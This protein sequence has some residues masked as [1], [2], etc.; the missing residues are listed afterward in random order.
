MTLLGNTS[1]PDEQ[2]LDPLTTPPA[3]AAEEGRARRALPAGTA[4][5][6][7]LRRVHFMAGLVVA[8]FLA[9]LAL[10]GL[11]YAFTPQLNDLLYGDELH[12]AQVGSAPRPV[13]DQVEAA[14]ARHPDGKVA[15]VVLP[16][17]PERTTEV[18]LAVPG[19]DTAGGEFAAENLTVYVDPY[20]AGVTGELITVNGRPPAQVWLRELHGNLG[21]G[22]PGR[23]YSEL[24]ASWLP[25]ILV[26]GLVLWLGG[27]RRARAARRA[28]GRARMRG[29]HG[30]IGLWAAVGLLV[31]S[32]TGLT[33]SQYAGGR[34]DQ[35]IGAL[36]AKSPS[37]RS[38]PITIPEGVEPVGFD[39]VVTAARA[40]GLQ[41]Q[42][43]LTPPA[44]AG[45]PYKVNETSTGL[46]VQKDS[47]AVDPY[48][49]AVTG[50]LG[51]DDYPF[52]AKLTT[53]GIQAHS[54]T[55]FGMANQLVMALLALAALV[56]T[57]LG[58]LMWWRRR[59]RSGGPAPVPPPVWRHMSQP[60][61]FGLVAAAAVLGWAMP[62]FGVSLVAFVLVDAAIGALA[63]RRA[64]SRLT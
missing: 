30:A 44:E 3:P 23:L 59:P 36:D 20:T 55:L 56:L 8:P 33:W 51:W 52:L 49:A 9:V 48:T 24:A 16:D 22:D 47:L 64:A 17:D 10:S 21:L 6:L 50:R 32:V 46:P 31:I 40:E 5:R 54:G 2:L 58:Y 29:L 61:A 57:V 41:G 45:R 60:V 39:R 38:A 12:V 13:A 11:A 1:P 27:R 7:L 37:L 34:V 15:S 14:L 35:L 18:V 4:V 26:G 19:L 43:T 25:F 42:L 28:G 53:L 63:R 62:V